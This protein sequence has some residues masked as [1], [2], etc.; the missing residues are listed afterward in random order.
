MWLSI[1]ELTHKLSKTKSE[2]FTASPMTFS[3]LEIGST[4][5]FQ[6]SFT[7]TRSTHRDGM[8]PVLP[9]NLGTGGAWI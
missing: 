8:H 2:R 7:W 3:V 9:G 4:G 5:G 6:P 1:R